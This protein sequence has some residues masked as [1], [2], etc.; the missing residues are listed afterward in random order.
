MKL[1]TYIGLRAIAYIIT[2]G[3]KVIQYGIKRMNIQFDNYYEFISGLPVSKRINKR[4]KAQAR[5]NLWRYK[6]RRNNLARTLEKT[7]GCKEQ[8]LSRNENLQLRVKGLHEKLPNQELTN[9][10]MQ[11]QNRRGYKSLRGVSDNEN[12]DYLKEIEAHEQKLKSYPSLAAYLL[13]LDSTKNVIVT[14]KT[15]EDEFNAI[16]DKQQ[17]DDK[18]RQKLFSLIYYQRPLKKPKISKCKYEKNRTVCHASNPIYQEFRIWR[19]VLN[20]SI[21]DNEN[22]ELEIS[23]EQRTN[24]FEKCN[25]GTNLTKASCLKDLGLKK[26]TQYKWYSGK[27]IAGNPINKAFNELK[28]DVDYYELWQDMYS[29]TDND[30]L[31][32]ILI[33]KYRFSEIVVNE[34]IDLDF[35]KL[36][37]AEFSMKAIRK[38]L[39]FMQQGVKLKEAILQQY[40]NV[41]FNEVALRNVVLEQHF[42]SYKA[43]I[44]QLQTKYS[45]DAIQFEIDHLLKQGNKG[46]KG[47]AQAKRKEEKFKKEHSELSDYN[48]LKLQLWEESGGICPYEPNVIIDKKELF[49]D[50]Y[51]ID[52]IIPKSKLFERGITNQVLCPKVLNEQKGRLTGLDF[53][54]N[55][56]IEEEYRKAVEKF[57]ESKQQFLLMSS[58]EIPNNWISKRQNQDYNTKCFATIGNATNIPNK[59]INRYVKEWSVNQ[60]NEQDARYYLCKAWVLA[61]MS[62]ET[63]FY[64][65]LIKDHSEGKTSVS[66]YNIQSF[67]DS[68]DFENA[69]V[70]MPRI[71]FVRKT[72]FGYTPRFALHQESV[73]G[74]RTFKTRNAKGELIENVLYKI[75]Q[76]MN[77][78]SEAMVLKVMDKSIREKIQKRINEIGNHDE[79]LISLLE[80]PITHNGKPIKRVS[81]AQ[82]A[83]MIYALRSTDGKGN[84]GKYNQYEKKIDYVYSDK[85]YA[86][87]IGLSAKGTIQKTVIPLLHFVNAINQRE[88]YANTFT[89]K[90]NEIIELDGKP[91]YLIGASKN[92]LLRSVYALSAE[93]KYQAKADDIKK[94]RK[95]YV[96]QLG[97]INKV[98]PF[99]T[100]GNTED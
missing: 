39:P 23:F 79:A 4:M 50:K 43:L 59:I 37:W 97:E 6:S 18:L 74:K 20:I 29:A 80:N 56:G 25:N 95:V 87:A 49:T 31:A 76:P 82:N 54:K 84:T 93:H 96:N 2:E 8:H 40:G 22:N 38:L 19:D 65:D 44:Q 51:N 47:I 63:I 88:Q 70:F 86:I 66:V 77:K 3:A 34:L 7:F 78:L 57:P 17:L 92:L 35:S 62:Q 30:K 81:I 45:F 75:R 64:F 53:A 9:V 10:L 67:I 42:D 26:P 46:R 13:T 15:Y 41:A 12:S 85:N 83:E 99:H 73:Y 5:K 69:P 91:Y 16:M 100:Y 98:I 52:H 58:S 32:H 27:T 55:I 72:K 61:N 36:G 11:L 48:R 94:I 90:E 33:N 71:K 1:N 14:R 60:Y 28:I 68:I 24:W 89:L 21:Y